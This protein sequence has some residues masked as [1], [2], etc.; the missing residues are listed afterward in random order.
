[1][2]GYGIYIYVDGVRYEGQFSNDKKEGFGIYYWI[3]GRIYEG[4]WHKGKQHG[5]G[6]Y[7]DPNKKIYKKGLW[8]FGK[9][10]KWF[11]ESQINE[12]N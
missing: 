3:D 9:R 1:M 5:I 12:I 4:Y 10:K 2:H 7:T 8:E 6:S 11:E